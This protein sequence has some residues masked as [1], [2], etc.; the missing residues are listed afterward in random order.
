MHRN[1]C[2]A[3]GKIHLNLKVTLSSKIKRESG[4]EVTGKAHIA[5]MSFK[6]QNFM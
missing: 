6:Y 4:F 1:C 5:N 2:T 3:A